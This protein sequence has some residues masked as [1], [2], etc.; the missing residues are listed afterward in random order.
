MW[1]RIKRLFSAPEPPRRQYVH[2]I[3][4]AFDFDADL[5]WKRNYRIDGRDVEIIIG[6]DGETPSAE[7]ENTAADWALHWGELRHTVL[8][9]RS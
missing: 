7:M 6:C 3:L 5:G 8:R 2:P 4:G 9:S 1:M